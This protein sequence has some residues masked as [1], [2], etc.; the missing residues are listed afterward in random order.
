M[1][2]QNR[3]YWYGFMIV[4]IVMI[5]MMWLGNQKEEAG[6]IETLTISELKAKI[7][8]NDSFPLMITS[9]YCIHCKELKELLDGYFKKHSLTIY[10]VSIDVESKQQEELMK[11]IKELFPSYVG[12]PNL[13]YIEEGRVISQYDNMNGELNEELF[14]RWIEKYKVKQ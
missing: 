1:K 9:E 13:F 3:K 12:T 14:H 7:K 5:M 10:E 4:L 8:D 6:K 11:E 2:Q